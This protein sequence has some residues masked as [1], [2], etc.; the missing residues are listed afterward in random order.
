MP[1]DYRVGG[2]RLGDF[3]L[4][5]VKLGDA[6]T[7]KKLEYD[8]IPIDLEFEDMFGKY[9]LLTQKRYAGHVINIEG[10]KIKD[11][12]KGIVLARR[13]NCAMLKTIYGR[14]LDAV[15][16]SLPEDAVWNILYAEIE[17]VYT[18]QIPD[19]Q[20]II[21]LAVNNVLSYA[22]TDGQGRFIQTDGSPIVGVDDPLDSRLVYPHLRQ[23]M[24]ALRMLKRGDSIPA[25]TRLEFVFVKRSQALFEG[26]R[27][28]DYDFYRENRK[29]L[30]GLALDI[31]HYIEK[32]ILKPVTELLNVTFPHEMVSAIPIKDRFDENSF[33]KLGEYQT[34]ILQQKGS[35]HAKVSHVLESANR[36][37]Y[38]G[39]TQCPEGVKLG[40]GDPCGCVTRYSGGSRN[41][42]NPA[43]HPQIMSVCRIFH[44]WNMV[45]RLQKQY[46]VPK[47][48][49]RR[50]G[51]PRGAT[52]YP[53]DSNVVGDILQARQLFR[54]VVVELNLYSLDKFYNNASSPE[55]PEGSL[56]SGDPLRGDESK[57]ST[58]LGS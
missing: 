43:K 37:D 52:E 26:D 42:V 6:D 27:L 5:E 21:Y 49:T 48:R 34:C 41:D 2:K 36:F 7:L 40:S 33:E 44:S 9:L 54:K 25:G 1:E 18:R 14:L 3:D 39:K 22:Q 11:V 50:K 15:L 13:D 56:G 10:A 47:S 38:L 45:A 16:E 17:K 31:D 35:I 24:L 55:P 20:F 46:G 28:E 8:S 12:R 57:T 30:K 58:I 51:L 4:A 29:G 32:Q 23:V 53:R 19:H